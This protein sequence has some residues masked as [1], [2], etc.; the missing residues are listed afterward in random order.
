MK[1][2]NNNDF[3]YQEL[4]W[5][6]IFFFLSRSFSDPERSGLKVAFQSELFIWKYRTNPKNN[7]VPIL[8]LQ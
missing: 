3:H 5:T 1:E 2:H 4:N 7:K 6:T 8:L